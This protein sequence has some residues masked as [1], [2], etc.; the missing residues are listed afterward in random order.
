[1]GVVYIGDRKTGK[2]NLAM[3]LANPKN[4]YVKVT[5][6]DYENLKQRLYDVN[7]GEF[8]ATDAEQAIYAE[9]L[10]IQVRLPTGNKQVLVDWIDTP[11]EVW[12]KTWQVDNQDKW[13]KFLETIHESEGILLILP[14]HRGLTFKSGVD[15]EQFMNQQQ[16]C[17]RFDRWVE[18]FRQDCS[19]TRHILICINKA[20]LFCDL[21]KEAAQLAYNPNGAQMNWQQRHTYVLQRYFRPIHSQLAQINSNVLGLSVRC[22]ITSIYNRSLLELPWIYLGSF[23]A[24]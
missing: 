17:N 23:L 5:S 18:F 10:D 13:Q 14:P 6:L 3:E 2:T 7:T 20:D 12:R 1:M 15:T 24:R 8:R 22:F 21:S 9:Y 11:G 4:E 19:K 16:W